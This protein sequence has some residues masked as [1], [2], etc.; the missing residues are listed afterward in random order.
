MNSLRTGN[1]IIDAIVAMIIP[2]ALHRSLRYFERLID[3]VLSTSNHVEFLRFRRIHKRCITHEKTDISSFYTPQENENEILI[4]AIIHHID[5]NKLIRLAR[6]KIN[7][8]SD[9][10]ATSMFAQQ[11]DAKALADVLKN[12][13]VIEKPHE[14][15]WCNVGSY[16]TGGTEKDKVWLKMHVYTEDISTESLPARR[17]TQIMYLQSRGETSITAFI[18]EAYESYME[19]LKLLIDDGTR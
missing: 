7:L 3:L 17:T 2:M 15:F 18:G 19:N 9:E 11:D 4:K 6:A 1:I 13:R 16:G 12:H 14:D 8:V 5:R 10:K